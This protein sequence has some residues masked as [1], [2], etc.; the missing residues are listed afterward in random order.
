MNA[1]KC[2]EINKSTQEHFA[3][4]GGWDSYAAFCEYVGGEA[5]GQWYEVTE[6]GDHF[7]VDTSK[8]RRRR[9]ALVVIV[10]GRL[11]EPVT[12]LGYYYID[13]PQHVFVDEDVFMNAIT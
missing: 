1:Y 4:V 9:I 13:E 2:A 3:K 8:M 12:V 5:S 7:E 10:H 6:G 11:F